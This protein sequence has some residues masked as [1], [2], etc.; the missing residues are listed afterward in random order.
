MLEKYGSGIN[1]TSMLLARR[2]VEAGV[3]FVTVFWKGNNELN[4]LCKSGGGW[5]W[6]THGN[7]FHCLEKTAAP[8]V[9]PAV[10]GPA[11]RPA[12]ARPAGRDAGDR[13]QRNGGANPRS[14]TPRSGG[15]T[16]AGRDHWTRCMSVLL[17]GGGIRGGQ[18]YGSSDKLAEFP[19]DK[20]VGA[21][22]IAQTVYHSL[23][24]DDPVGSRRARSALSPDGRRPPADGTV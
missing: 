6:D 24:I 21:E 15:T 5:D 1:A 7:N 2:L 20:P 8:R 3:P 16:G 23:G 10:C 11:R 18:V 13:L 9:R 17:A 4:E 22:H 12:P 14:A 19:R